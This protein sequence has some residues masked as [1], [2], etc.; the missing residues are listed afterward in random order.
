MREV[1]EKVEREWEWSDGAC[2]REE[3]NFKEKK[4]AEIINRTCRVESHAINTTVFFHDCV[5]QIA[6]WV[7]EGLHR[8]LAELDARRQRNAKPRESI[9][10]MDWG[11][12][13][14][15]EGR[16]IRKG[17]SAKKEKDEVIR[18]EE[19]VK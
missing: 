14:E 11:S 12:C 13:G 7:R 17:K 8:K 2:T 4:S 6:Y 1:K 18:R 15:G 10:H 3:Q 5:A 16:K 9:L 19:D